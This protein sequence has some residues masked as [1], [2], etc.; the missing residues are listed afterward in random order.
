MN[1]LLLLSGLLVSTAAQAQIIGRPIKTYTTRMGTP[2][3]IG[4]TIA[5]ARGQRENG[6]FK[7][8]SI[9]VQAFHLTEESLPATWNYRKAVIKQ[10]REMPYKTGSVV[11]TVFKSGAFNAALNADAAEESGEIKTANNQKKAT[12]TNGG[13]ADELIKLKS[14]LDAGTITQAEFDAQ[15]AKLLK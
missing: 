9:A 10:L 12:P 1:K 4:D 15:K 3:H 5:F 2:L 14:L 7:Y 11:T 13:V 6:S 8:A